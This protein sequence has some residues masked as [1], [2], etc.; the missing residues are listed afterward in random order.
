MANLLEAAAN[1][2]FAVRR[3]LPD[4]VKAKPDAEA[5]AALSREEEAPMGSGVN[6]KNAALVAQ[7]AEK[8]AK[9]EPL[10]LLK[11]GDEVRINGEP[12]TL[13][14]DDELWREL[15]GTAFDSALQVDPEHGVSPVKLIDMRF[16]IALGELGG[17][18]V[19]RQDLPKEAFIDLDTLKRLERP[20]HRPAHYLD[21]SHPWQ[22]PD[23]PDPKEVNRSYS[24]RS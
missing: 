1:C 20:R 16:I 18:M 11:K 22:Q 23:H 15:G 5:E 2:L 19:R 14:E 24:R 13:Q 17:T 12:H 7:A 6:T 8:V 9:A 3:C 10:K 4:P 21:L